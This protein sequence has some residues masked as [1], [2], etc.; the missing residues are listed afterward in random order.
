[1]AN[2]LSNQKLRTNK[3]LLKAIPFIKSLQ[4]KKRAMVV[5]KAFDQ[6]NLAAYQSKAS[7]QNK[8]F[9]HICLKPNWV[10]INL[11]IHGDHFRCLVVMPCVFL[12][13]IVNATQ[14]KLKTTTPRRLIGTKNKNRSSVSYHNLSLFV[15]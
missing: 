15:G 3:V 1:M 5:K 4:K 6:P 2:I 10:S 13:S 9:T 12:Q 11:L 7:K 14:A 8:K